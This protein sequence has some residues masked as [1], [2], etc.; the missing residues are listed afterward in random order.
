MLLNLPDIPD[1]ALIYNEDETRQIL[2]FFWPG[3]SAAINEM[4]IDNNA[5]R[6][7]QS[8]LIAAIDGS[9]SLGFVDSLVRA[10]S[11]PNRG[12]SQLVKRLARSFGRHEW[13]HAQQQDLENVRIYDAVRNA[14]AQALRQRLKMI[15]DGVAH[16]RGAYPFYAH[17]E[18]LNR[19]IWS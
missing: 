7:A 18:S 8:A 1:N 10:L 4:Q 15:Q 16:Q 2:K 12:L 3:E 13:R 5:R 9:Y 14:V 17:V 6:L 19:L 11:R